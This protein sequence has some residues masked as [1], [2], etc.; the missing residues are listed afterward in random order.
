MQLWE[1]VIPDEDYKAG[2]HYG[3]T[4]RLSCAFYH[5]LHG[6]AALDWGVCFK[7][8]PRHGLLNFEHFGCSEWRRAAKCEQRAPSISCSFASSGCGWCIPR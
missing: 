8:R 6:Q 1:A 2:R 4:Q 7:P 5:E 3:E